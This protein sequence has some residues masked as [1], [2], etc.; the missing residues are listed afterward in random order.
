MNRRV[1]PRLLLVSVLAGLVVLAS[2]CSSSPAKSSAKSPNSSKSTTPRTLPKSIT[3]ETS[4]PAT[5][6]PPRSAPPIL[7]AGV[8]A[9]LASSSAT[10]QFTAAAITSALSTSA[11]GFTHGGKTFTVT[12]T[13]VSYSGGAVSATGPP[14][15]NVD[16]VV[17]THA[18]NGVLVTMTL[19]KAA[20]TY[21][22]SVGK[23]QVTIDLS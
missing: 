8:V 19:N 4:P 14:T 5:T 15:Y 2:A 23:N 17:V 9:E 3:H 21:H 22:F 6:A 7:P 13:G 20:S 1:C 11:P 16:S 18:S 12:I 10:I